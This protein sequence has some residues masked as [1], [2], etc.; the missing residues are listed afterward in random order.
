VTD[1]SRN[2]EGGGR[3]CIIPVVYFIANAHN[4]LY[5]FYTGK[6][7]LM[8]KMKPIGGGRSYSPTPCESANL[9]TT[10]QNRVN[11]RGFPHFHFLFVFYGKCSPIAYGDSVFMKRG[12]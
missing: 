8:K 4:E 11:D 12:V 2:F 10:L 6:D 1:G 7:D 9:Y 3:Q 5:A